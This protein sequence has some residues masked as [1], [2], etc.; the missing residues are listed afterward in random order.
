MAAPI[1]SFADASDVLARRVRAQL[2]K[3]AGMSQQALADRCGVFCTYLS[4]IENSAANPSLLVLAA[5]AIAL[6][7]KIGDLLE[8]EDEASDWSLRQ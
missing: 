4:R 5:L 2:R 3:A 7:V 1:Q 6:G 8:E